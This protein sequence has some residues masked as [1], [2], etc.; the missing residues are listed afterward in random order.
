MKNIIM[1][2]F[3]II[4]LTRQLPVWSNISKQQ[5]RMYTKQLILKFEL[6]SIMDSDEFSINKCD[7]EKIANL[8]YSNRSVLV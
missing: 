7:V 1:S 3:S 5:F 6:S 4:D 8:I 2:M